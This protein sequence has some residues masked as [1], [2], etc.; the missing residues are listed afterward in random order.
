M[1]QKLVEKIVSKIFN[2]AIDFAYILWNEILLWVNTIFISWVESNAISLIEESIELAFTSI[3]NITYSNLESIR[4]AWQKIKQFLI[5]MTIEYEISDSSP[6]IWKKRANST[7]LKNLSG[8]RPT[9]IKQELE[10][11]VD[12]DR[13]PSEIRET[14]L[15]K[16]D[17]LYKID[18]RETRDKELETITLSH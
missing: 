5:E 18:F 8:N 16:K 17:G 13:L 1:E 15:R 11:D 12:W 4:N 3:K 14:W 6:G 9:I 10:E 2:I 7:I